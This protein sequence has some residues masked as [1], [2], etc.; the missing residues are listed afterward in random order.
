MSYRLSFLQ[1][2]FLMTLLVAVSLTFP[3]S[4]NSAIIDEIARDFKPLSGYVVMSSEDEYII[5]LDDTKGVAMGDIFSVVKPGKQIVHP[6]TGKVLGTLEEIKGVLKVIRIKSGYS[7]ARALGKAE[8]IKKGDSI[9][10]YESL[11]AFFWDHTGK[12]RSFFVQLQSALP[13]LKWQDYDEAQRSRL[14]KARPAPEEYDSL[15]F[16]LTDRGVEVQGPDSSVIHTYNLPESVSAASGVPSA[17]QKEHPQ[18]AAAATSTAVV[19]KPTTAEPIKVTPQPT[20]TQET[21]LFK[22]DFENVQTIDTIPGF[23]VMTDF[24]KNENQLLMATTD[25]TAIEVYQVGHDL[26][27][28]AKVSP[29]YPGQILA[30]KWWQPVEKGP[31]Y[32]AAVT[33]A[34]KAVEGTVFRLED[35]NLIPLKDRVSRILGTFDLDADGRPETL[36]GQSFDGENF[37]GSGIKE[38][39]LIN[40]KLKNYNPPISFPRRFTVLG[41]LFADLTG[42]G[43]S[44]TVF[45]R[46]GILYIYQG[47]Q[48]LYASPKQMGGS[49]SFLTYDIDPGFKSLQTTSAEFEISPVAADIDGDGQLEI[50][51][52]AA[53]KNFLGDVAAAPG[54]KKSWLEVFKYKDRKVVT[55]TLGDEM[56]TP[57]QGLVVDGKRV[58]IVATQAGNILGKGR[59]SH[60]LA[61]WLDL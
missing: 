6:V 3:A 58:L 32:L 28:L 26:T 17:T 49:L 47:K 5:D 36:F 30:L 43:K 48:R 10:R 50:I 40:G 54:I 59:S 33:W 23:S 14:Q 18:A 56:E 31:L 25:G 19:A 22:P 39:K 20:M 7:F 46:G 21:A 52:V 61:Y 8:E 53:E 57:L 2:Y 41:S 38:L 11:R 60:L 45:I 27:P 16:M 4:A 55:G 24:I 51:A 29:P 1:K 15:F 13:A 37:F 44:E 34:N 42:D 12:G 35:Q 9:R